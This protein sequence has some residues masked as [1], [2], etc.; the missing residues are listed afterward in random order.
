M[1]ITFKKANDYG[2]LYLGPENEAEKCQIEALRKSMD[3]NGSVYFN[4]GEYGIAILAGKILNPSFV[5]TDC[6]GNK[7][8]GGYISMPYPPCRCTWGIVVDT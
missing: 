3:G 5:E 4:T 1:K 7:L 2:H 8:N 6:H